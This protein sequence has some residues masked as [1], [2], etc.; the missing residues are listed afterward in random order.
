MGN[1]GGS[2]PRRSDLVKSKAA[3][4]PWP[5]HPFNIRVHVDMCSKGTISD[6]AMIISMPHFRSLFLLRFQIEG[7]G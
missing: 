2:I 7:Q 1:D 5:A 3:I 6:Y 4:K